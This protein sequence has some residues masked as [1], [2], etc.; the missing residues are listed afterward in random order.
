M[1]IAAAVCPGAPLLVPE[2]ATERSDALAELR[3]RCRQALDQVSASR[4]DSITVVGSGP[5]TA[6]FGAEAVGSL[7]PYGPADRIRLTGERADTGVAVLPLSLSLGAWLLA[8]VGWHGRVRGLSVAESSSSGDCVSLGCQY[9]RE[10][11]R[12]ALL[13]IA[14]GSARRSRQAPGYWDRRAAGFDEAVAAALAAVDRTALLRVDPELAR[15]LLAAG[16]APLQ[17]LAGA[18]TDGDWRADLLWHEAP[19][20]VGYFVATWRRPTV[21]NGDPGLPNPADR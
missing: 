19:Y 16:R 11:G 18:A 2:L 14:D 10:P 8:E 5:R 13:V 15:D 4:P 7:A 9:A 6:T 17:V 21:G 3:R 1:L 20:G 12:V